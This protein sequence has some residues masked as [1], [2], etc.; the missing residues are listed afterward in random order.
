[1]IRTIYSVSTFGAYLACFYFQWRSRRLLYLV[2]TIYAVS[3]FGVHFALYIVLYSICIVHTHHH[4]STHV[5]AAAAHLWIKHPCDTAR[6]CR[7]RRRVVRAMWKGAIAVANIGLPGNAITGNNWNKQHRPALKKQFKRLLTEN[8]DVHGLSLC[9]VGNH[10]YPLT[11]ECRERMR[12]LIN[13]VFT[14]VFAKATLSQQG[15]PTIIWPQ[16]NHG[17]ETLTAW[18]ADVQ[19]TP[20]GQLTPPKQPAYRV[21]ERVKLSF[22]AAEH[23]RASSSSASEHAH[24]S[25]LVYNNHQPASDTRPFSS[26]A[27]I[28]FLKA[29][30]KDAIDI[31]SGL[32]PLDGPPEHVGQA[33]PFVGFIFTGDANCNYILWNTALT[34]DPTWRFVFEEPQYMYASTEA[35]CNAGKRKRGDIIVSMAVKNQNFMLQQQNCSTPNREQQHDCL[36]AQWC[37]IA[38][39][40]DFVEALLA[41]NTKTAEPERHAS[42]RDAGEDFE[43][44]ES[45]QEPDEVESTT[46]QPPDEG[47]VDFDVDDEE[48]EDAEEEERKNEKMQKEREREEYDTAIYLAW[49]VLQ[50]PQLRVHRGAV[51][52]LKMAEPPSRMLARCDENGRHLLL[53]AAQAFFCEQPKRTHSGAA[54]HAEPAPAIRAKPVEV[55]R[56]AWEELFKKRQL[57]EADDTKPINNPASLSKLW[58]QCMHQWMAENLTPEQKER[59]TSRKTRIFSAHVKHTYGGKH[60]VMALWQTG[61]TW[62][63][64]PEEIASNEEAAVQAVKDRFLKWLQKV[65]DAIAKH[66]NDIPTEEARRRSGFKKWHHGLTRQEEAD[67]RERKQARSDFQWTRTLDAEFM[68]GKGKGKTKAQQNKRK[69]KGTKGKPREW[70]DFNS[71]EQWWLKQL[72][73]GNLK[74]RMQEAEAKMRPVQAR[75]F[76]M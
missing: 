2:R 27:R 11:G 73:N 23:G 18:R 40:G 14:E 51:N 67:R 44:A 55:T 20:L 19:V 12:H 36:I 31:C 39:Q 71:T 38:H 64:T 59:V 45:A 35:L 37:Y 5:R 53:K 60:F 49:S 29:V 50:L 30:I 34:E 26:Y 1:M 69:G 54:E 3:T 74:R 46:S 24:A 33:E 66:K 42:E 75:T 9:E 48:P 63:P 17:G 47:S 56:A 72:W 6:C 25:I 70:D 16:G 22:S 43:D 76:Q 13:E 21:V 65:F 61:I 28:Q 7:A 15:L 4:T 52:C 62:L 10:D 68:A 57:V 8:G 58:T 41:Q 32:V